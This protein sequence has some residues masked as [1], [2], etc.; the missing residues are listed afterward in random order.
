MRKDFSPSL[1]LFQALTQPL[2]RGWHRKKKFTRCCYF[3]IVHSSFQIVRN[4]FLF[5]INY[6]AVLVID[7]I[8]VTKCLTRSSLKKEGWVYTG[9]QCAG[10][11]SVMPRKAW[12]LELGMLRL[13]SRSRER[14]MAQPMESS[15]PHLVSAFPFQ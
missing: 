8:V 7:L 2:N 4:G 9:L 14:W 5:C 11:H 13:Q 6:S 12:W 10:I 15:F 3:L 1:V